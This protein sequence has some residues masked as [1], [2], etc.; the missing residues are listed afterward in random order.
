MITNGFAVG[1]S[2]L[3][4]LDVLFPAPSSYIYVTGSAG[5]IVFENTSGNPQFWPEAQAFNLYPIAAR[6][7]L[8]DGVVNG[9]LRTTTATDLSYGASTKI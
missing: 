4:T 5:D 1:L 7:I 8:T 9:T 3:V 6:R 2:D